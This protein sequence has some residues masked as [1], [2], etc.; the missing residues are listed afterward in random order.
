LTDCQ[1][2]LLSVGDSVKIKLE[3]GW[4]RVLVNQ[5]VANMLLEFIQAVENQI[6]DITAMIYQAISWLG[7]ALLM[8]VE[9]T[10]VPLPSEVIMPLAGWLLAF[11]QNLSVGGIFWAGLIGALGSVGGA[12]V[13]YW[14]ARWGGRPLIVKYGR[15]ILVSESDIVRAE[16]WFAKHGW[17]SVFFLR[18]VPGLRGFVAIPAG[19]AKMNVVAFGVLTFLAMLPWTT[20]LAWGGY[21]L[22][23][24]Y[25]VISD[26]LRP[27][28]IPIALIAALALGYFIWRRLR[29]IRRER[30]S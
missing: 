30:A 11:E 2:N 14:A 26:W 28:Y 23:E 21:A 1:T 13:E 15:F 29:T 18:L 7:V 25:T 12:L 10:A 16:R 22:G 24:N 27:F 3:F 19:V 17:W 4:K 5:G 9:S 6:I 20:L 8:A